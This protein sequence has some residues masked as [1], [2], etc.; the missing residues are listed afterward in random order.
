[1]FGVSIDYAGGCSLADISEPI[2]DKLSLGRV[3]RYEVDPENDRDTWLALR[4]HDFTAS[5][6]GSLFGVGFKGLREVYYAKKGLISVQSSADVSILQRGLDMEPVIWKKL[7]QRRPT[8]Q[9][10][11]S[12]IYLRAPRLRLGATPDALAH[13]P[14]RKHDVVNEKWLEGDDDIVVPQGYVL[15]TL[16]ETMLAEARLGRI[17]HPYVV[18]CVDDGRRALELFERPIARNPALERQILVAVDNVRQHLEV[19]AQFHAMSPT[20]QLIS[21]PSANRIAWTSGEKGTLPAFV[22]PRGA[23]LRAQ[24]SRSGG[25]WRCADIMV[26]VEDPE[27]WP[28]RHTGNGGGEVRG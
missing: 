7:A 11:P 16:T 19:W 25:G 2:L 3:E 15:Q 6:T 10:L 14:A 8:W 12:K 4:A 26:A 1:V 20:A 24:I 28:L 5:D 21:R 13:D 23:V 22:I 9:L 17:V 27:G 18:A